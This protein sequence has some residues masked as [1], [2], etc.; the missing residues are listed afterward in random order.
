VSILKIDAGLAVV[1]EPDEATQQAPVIQVGDQV[2][3]RDPRVGPWKP[4]TIVSQN[5][6]AAGSDIVSRRL[7]ERYV[8][9]GRVEVWREQEAT[10]PIRRG[11]RA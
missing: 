4:V 11:R 7:L 5:F 1:D 6:V 3:I 9:Q 8:A 10:R 2:R